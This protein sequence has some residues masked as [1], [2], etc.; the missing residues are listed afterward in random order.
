MKH[1]L[2]KNN[3]NQIYQYNFIKDNPEKLTNWIYSTKFKKY[4]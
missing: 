2:I 3:P 1:P 4:F